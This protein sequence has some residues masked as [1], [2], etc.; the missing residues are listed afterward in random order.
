MV[1][2]VLL[3]PGGGSPWSRGFSLVPGVLLG[4][5]GFSLVPEGSPWSSGGSPWSWGSFYL[6]LGGVFLV[7]GGLPGPGGGSLE[8][9][10]VYRITDTCKN[11]T[12]ATTLLR[13][14]ATP[15]D[16]CSDSEVTVKVN[17]SELKKRSKSGNIY[18]TT[19]VISTEESCTNQ[20][21]AYSQQTKTTQPR[22]TNMTSGAEH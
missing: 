19:L 8:T 7:W 12:L 18:S 20:A 3:G 9:P 15:D 1:W 5:E 11:I 17:N 16:Y 6:V 13:P 22:Y 2:G 4:P 21:I 10:P 14:V